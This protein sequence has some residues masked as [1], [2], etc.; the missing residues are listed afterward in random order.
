MGLYG[1][2]SKEFCGTRTVNYGSGTNLRIWLSTP[3][4]GHHSVRHGSRS[5]LNHAHEAILA[6]EHEFKTVLRWM[7]VG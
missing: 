4:L 1:E 2:M 6:A 7:K 5:G 3:A